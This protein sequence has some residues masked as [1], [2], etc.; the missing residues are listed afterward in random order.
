VAAFGPSVCVFN[1]TM[2][3]ASIQADLDK[4]ANQQVS[5][6]FGTS[7]GMSGSAITAALAQGKGPH[8]DP[9]RL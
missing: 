5:N 6:Q 4:I 7:P 3:Q 8:P 1:T 9:R 2:S